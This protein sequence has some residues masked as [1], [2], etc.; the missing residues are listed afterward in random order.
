MENES[1]EKPQAAPET[2]TLRYET[3]RIEAIVTAH[4]VA[5]DAM[6]THYRVVS[7]RKPFS[8]GT[9]NHLRRAGETLTLCQGIR[10]DN[11]GAVDLAEVDCITCLDA[12]TEEMRP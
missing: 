3:R 11:G 10:T 1:F 12:F 7:V 8:G 5:M 2:T 4:Q 6:L 9:F